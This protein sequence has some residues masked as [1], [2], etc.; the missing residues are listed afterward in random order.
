MALFVG[1]CANY[2]GILRFYPLFGF[3]YTWKDAAW[4]IAGSPVHAIPQE[5]ALQ[6]K[7][8]PA[9]SAA[10]QSGQADGNGGKIWRGLDGLYPTGGR[11]QL[12]WQV[13]GRVGKMGFDRGSSLGWKAW[14][15]RLFRMCWDYNTIS[16]LNSEFDLTAVHTGLSFALSAAVVLAI[17]V[18]SNLLFSRRLRT[19]DIV[20]VFKSVD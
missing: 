18:F 11:S 19:L 12:E 13:R 6:W 20:T 14:L 5:S 3:Q 8:A 7:S 16:M 10:C 17:F 2:M 15:H 9:L 4:G 1:Y